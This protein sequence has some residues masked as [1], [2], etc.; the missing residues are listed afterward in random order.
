MNNSV[1]ID[2]TSRRMVKVNMGVAFVNQ[3]LRGFV[4]DEKGAWPA[5]HPTA[6]AAAG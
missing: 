6:I 2:K 1:G 5:I 4:G 3:F